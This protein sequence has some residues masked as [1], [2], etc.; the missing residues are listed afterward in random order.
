MAFGKYS[1]KSLR[2]LSGQVE[3]G[4]NTYD[5]PKADAH[6]RVQIK[7]WKSDIKEWGFSTQRYASDALKSDSLTSLYWLLSVEKNGSTFLD[8]D[9]MCNAVRGYLR[10][11]SNNIEKGLE[12]LKFIFDFSPSLINRSFYNYVLLGIDPRVDDYVL[13]IT[14]DFRS[15][16][17]EE[18]ASI[19]DLELYDKFLN[20][21]AAKDEQPA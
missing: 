8:G 14:R 18:I 6:D 7:E 17:Y 21:G 20:A 11:D 3:L 19:G 13:K 2:S 10:A 4:G 15:S 12:T 9:D 5:I 16:T 1:F